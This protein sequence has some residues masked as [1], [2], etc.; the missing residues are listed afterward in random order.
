MEV[1]TT[2]EVSVAERLSVRRRRESAREESREH[3]RLAKLLNYYLDP[4]TTFWSSL[5]NKP[6]S[7]ISGMF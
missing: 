7:A 3:I 2:V 5:E 4:E 1:V 6:R